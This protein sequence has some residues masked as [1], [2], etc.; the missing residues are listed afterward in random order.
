MEINS[1]HRFSKPAIN[2]TNQRN[3][4]LAS[5]KFM[6][7]LNPR[8]NVDTW[9]FKAYEHDQLSSIL[10]EV[11][12]K[13]GGEPRKLKKLTP[14]VV[15]RVPRRL[16]AIL[17]YLHEY[18]HVTAAFTDIK[19]YFQMLSTEERE[20]LLGMAAIVMVDRR[21]WSCVDQDEDLASPKS[22]NFPPT[23]SYSKDGEKCYHC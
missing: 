3:A 2:K 9:T 18:G 17:E 10:H 6:V 5:V 13:E 8:R 16:L 19:P 14:Y 22:A 11:E 21:G 12:L 7:M 23:V 4:R 20:Q 15:R 1:K